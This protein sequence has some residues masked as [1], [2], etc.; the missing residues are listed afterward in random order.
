MRTTVAPRAAS[1]RDDL[2]HVRGCAVVRLEAEALALMGEGA[3]VR[4][5]RDAEHVVR[6]AS[7]EEGGGAW[8]GD[9][10]G[11]LS[12]AALRRLDHERFMGWP[13]D[14]N[15]K[16]L[17]PRGVTG[18]DAELEPGDRGEQIS[19]E[20]GVYRACHETMFTITPPRN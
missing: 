4:S 1:A 19:A 6:V 16:L 7:D 11:P 18:G 13:I 2:G 20:S 14:Q 10:Q 15:P 3:I 12:R 17:R 8:R 5:A 9:A